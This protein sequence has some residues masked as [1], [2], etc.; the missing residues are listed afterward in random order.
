MGWATPQREAPML[1]CRD[2][3][4][5]LVEYLDGALDPAMAHALEAHLADCQE[6]TAFLNT[7]RGTVRMT[8]QL[9]EEDLPAALRERLLAFLRQR[10]RS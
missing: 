3:V 8:R 7:Y 2:I 10:I 9:R 5:L 1:R 4:E 6:C